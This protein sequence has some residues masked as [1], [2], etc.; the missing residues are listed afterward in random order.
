MTESSSV[1][2]APTPKVFAFIIGINEYF[3]S[4]YLFPLQGAVN[5]AKEFERYLLDPR[6]QRGLGVPP[7]NIVVLLDEQATRANILATFQSHFIDN[8]DIPDKGNAAMIFFYAGHGC[9]ANA[10]YN[11]INRDG[12][13]EAICPVDQRTWNAEGNYVYAIPDYVLGWLLKELAEKKGNNITVIFDACHS[14]GM[15]RDGGK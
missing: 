9:R 6:E 5:D 2:G 13:V 4:D 15:G 10:P 11:M 8:P 7:S 1:N 12:L 3:S 14:G